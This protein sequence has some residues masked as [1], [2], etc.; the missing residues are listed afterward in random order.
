MNPLFKKVLGNNSII[1]PGEQFVINTEIY[2]TN[3]QNIQKYMQV[4]L[5]FNEKGEIIMKYSDYTNSN[6]VLIYGINTLKTNFEYTFSLIKNT[7]S[8]VSSYY[9]YKDSELLFISNKS[10]VLSWKITFR[11]KNI[12]GI[13]LTN[14]LKIKPL[15]SYI[16]FSLVGAN[17]IDDK[18]TDV[19]YIYLKNGNV[20][21]VP[22][23]S[24]KAI[25]LLSDNSKNSLEK[26]IFNN[27]FINNNSSN[28]SE[29]DKCCFK[30]KNCK[31]KFCKKIKLILICLIAT[32]LLLINKCCLKKI[33][34]K[35][36]LLLHK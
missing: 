10:D 17:V 2:F 23:S 16:N 32:I 36:I 8:P 20:G 22:S 31:R 15:T 11:N 19:V 4:I 30:K 28:S 34:C 9:K 24:K 3:I 7:S 5:L 25:V 27:N 18:L 21:D 1:Y 35:L 29:T 6:D 14:Y 26:K 13:Y 33:I 12:D